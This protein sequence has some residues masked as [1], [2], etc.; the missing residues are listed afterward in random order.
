MGAGGVGGS[1][2]LPSAGPTVVSRP[3]PPCRR[4][5]RGLPLPWDPPGLLC[6]TAETHPNW[7]PAP[8]VL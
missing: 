6:Q 8:T 7:E 5:A 2:C 4:C 3:M 1:Q